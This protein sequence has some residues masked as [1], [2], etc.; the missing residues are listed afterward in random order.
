M[1]E[2]GL[3]RCWAPL[4]WVGAT[5]S[6][7]SA[8]PISPLGHYS[9]RGLASF[10]TLVKGLALYSLYRSNLHVSLVAATR[11]TG[12]ST[13][14]PEQISSNFSTTAARKVAASASAF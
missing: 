7:H 13:A 8:L 2:M 5:P 12:P 10:T 14:S 11:N 1:F 4:I 9:R 3:S 6:I